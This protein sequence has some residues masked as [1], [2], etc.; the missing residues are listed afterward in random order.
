MGVKRVQERAH[1][2]AAHA[3]GQP[4]QVVV[5]GGQGVRLLVVE[6]LGAVFDP[7]QKHISLAQRIGGGLWHELGARQPRQ[8]VQRGPGAQF[9]ELP[10]AHH[11]QQLHGEL[12]LADAAARE[13]HVVGAARVAG[14][15]LGRVFADLAVQDAQRI[16]HAVVEVLAEHERQHQGT[17]CA[18]A[19]V[20]HTD[21]R[22][23]HAALE[24][25]KTFPLAALH[26]EVGFQR[27]GGDRA[28]PGIS[29]GPQRQIDAKHLAVFGHFTDRV[30]DVLDRLGEVLVVADAVAAVFVAGGLAVF[31]VDVDQIDVAGDV[32][33]ARAEFAHADHPE[34]GACG[35]RSAFA[36]W[37]VIQR[38]R[39]A[40][41]RVEFGEGEAAGDIE[42][43]FGQR[44]HGAGDH[45]QALA[46]LAV[47]HRKPLQRQL[48]QHPQRRG[49]GQ[50]TGEQRIKTRLQR[51]VH[52]CARWQQVELGGI[53][54]AHPL[55][56]TRVVRR[57]PGTHVC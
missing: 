49:H 9:G 32:E 39:G 23:N 1:A 33:L 18:G 8:G 48:A 56:K 31:V 24:P 22:C 20:A 53:A 16:E 6:V 25:G 15:A 46:L 50:T 17:Q 41:Q 3:G 40:M 4:G 10:A 36:Q 38:Q 12:D 51:L 55:H 28:W 7:A 26:Q 37:C 47:E 19:A 57:R 5:A 30:V 45:A 44:G 42:R 11:L 34:L 43:E 54:A 27:T 14:G 52:R 2:G 29:V 21:A 35:W 13:F